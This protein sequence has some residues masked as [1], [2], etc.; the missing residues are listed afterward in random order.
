MIASSVTGALCISGGTANFNTLVFGKY[1]SGS[2]TASITGG[3]VTASSVLAGDMGTCSFAVSNAVLHT[4]TLSVGEFGYGTMSV[5]SSIITANVAKIAA[6]WGVS[7][8]SLE[9]GTASFGTL[10]VGSENPGLIRF[11]YDGS[12]S[13]NISGG[14]LTVSG[15]TRVASRGYGSIRMS[16]GEAHFG[17]IYMCSVSRVAYE[18]TEGGLYIPVE[19]HDGTMSNGVASIVVNGG[20]FSSVGVT[21]V[22]QFGTGTLSITSGT[23]SFATLSV[24][25]GTGSCSGSLEVSNA[26]QFAVAHDLTVGD[27]GRMRLTVVGAAS[28]DTLVGSVGGVLSLSDSGGYV[29]DL[30]GLTTEISLSDPMDVF[31]TSALGA[32]ATDAQWVIEGYAFATPEGYTLAAFWD[33]TTLQVGLVAIPEPAWCAALLGLVGLALAA[34]RRG[35]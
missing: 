13:L 20:T 35:A 26:A 3:V 21:Q 32:G 23:A 5:S 28:G 22:G 1:Y 16:A 11:G 34:R 33:D 29:I 2:A 24:G 6:I 14:V 12:G 17:D 27:Y 18:E 19:E 4:T 15:A 31:Y 25:A 7:L 30:S 9:S 10:V 8:M